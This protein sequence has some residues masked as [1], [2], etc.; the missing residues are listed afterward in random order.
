MLP[1]ITFTN[2]VKLI[3]LKDESIMDDN[4]PC[5]QNHAVKD[6][7]TQGNAANGV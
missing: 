6:V 5:F 1:S 3:Y 2:L 7:P 4:V